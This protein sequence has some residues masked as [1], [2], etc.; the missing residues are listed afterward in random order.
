MTD[1]DLLNQALRYLG[2][3][4]VQSLT[5]KT[6]SAK[7]GSDALRPSVEQV[8]RLHHWN[9]ALKREELNRLVEENKFGPKYCYQLPNDFLKLV[10]FN[11][12]VEDFQIEGDCLQVGLQYFNQHHWRNRHSNS[13][14]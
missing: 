9:S 5:Q 13:D 6:N 11:D 14:A 10:K 1:V 8:L 3:S 4:R 7:Y 2:E 12:G